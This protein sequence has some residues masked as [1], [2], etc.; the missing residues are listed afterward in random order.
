MGYGDD[1]WTLEAVDTIHQAF[2]PDC[3]VYFVFNGTGSNVV[4]LQT[5]TRPFNSILCAETAH[6]AV[7]ECGAPAKMTGCHI[8][9]IPTPDGKLTPELIKPYLVGFGEQHHSQPGAIYLSECSELGTIYTPDEL[10]AITSLAHEH[11]INIFKSIV[12]VLILCIFEIERLSNFLEDKF[13]CSSLSFF[14][15]EASISRI[16]KYHFG[17]VKI[18]S[19]L[20]QMFTSE[21]GVGKMIFVRQLSSPPYITHYQYLFVRNHNVLILCEKTCFTGPFLAPYVCMSLIYR[22]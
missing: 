3:D 1:P 5:I 7:D 12:R 22:Q 13:L 18:V 11:P 2:T 16:K 14:E 10:K 8:C 21:N 6:I 19:V 17:M 9:T 15:N 4:A 20:L